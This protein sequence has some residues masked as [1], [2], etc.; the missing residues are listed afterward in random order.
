MSIGGDQRS[1]ILFDLDGTLIDSAPDIRTALNEVLH[2]ASLPVVTLEQTRSFVGDGAARLVQRAF[3]S[4]GVP[5]H[6]SALSLYRDRYIR[7]YEAR[8]A[9]ETRLYPHV[10]HTLRTLRHAGWRLAVC[11]NKPHAATLSV[12][13]QLALDSYFETA[14]GGDSFAVRKPDPGHLLS[15]LAAL[16]ATAD[17][18]IMV[19]DSENDVRAAQRANIPVILMSHGYHH[20]PVEDMAADLVLDSFDNFSENL[21]PL[22]KAVA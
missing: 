19:G 16:G 8:L 7:A 22:A 17:Q 3:T 18:A 20:G 13:R 6:A 4:V 15:T 10:P 2:Q 11:T 12:M 14:A 5:L 1:I 21:P 9:V